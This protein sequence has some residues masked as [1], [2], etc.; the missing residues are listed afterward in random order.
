MI[1][2]HWF[3]S[4][5]MI[6]SKQKILS[7]LRRAIDGYDLISEGDRIAVGVSGGKDSLVLL[8]ALFNYSKF[9][10]YSFSVVG[11]TIDTFPNTDF[12]N[13]EEFCKSRGIEYKIVKSDI[14][15]IVFEERKEKNPCSLCSKLRRGM[16][17]TTALELGCN[18]LALGHSMD[19]V[20]HTYLLSMCYEGRISTLAPMSYLDRTG[21]TVIRPLYLTDERDIISASHDLPIVK[22]N[23]PADK[24]TKREYVKDIVKFIQQEIPCV[25][26]RI[27][28]AI[29]HPERINLPPELITKDNKKDDN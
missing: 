10:P 20:V 9:S 15:K 24:H 18:K 14:Y 12:N 29:T 23:C 3:R 25:K 19:D 17:N 16:L 4:E 21:M 27:F 13:V 26:D 1:Q 22:S 5:I 2:L 6:N 7:S 28:G 8:E 11:I